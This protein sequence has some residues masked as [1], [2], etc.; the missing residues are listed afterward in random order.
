MDEHYGVSITDRGGKTPKA[1]KAPKDQTGERDEAPETPKG[2]GPKKAKDF[3]FGGHKAI[4]IRGEEGP[5]DE[6]CK[7]GKWATITY[8][9][10]DIPPVT[11]EYAHPGIASF[12]HFCVDCRREAVKG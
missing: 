11:D 7:C 6:R 9:V 4:V 1:A 10:L 2:Q 8:A 3:R 5:K 12:V